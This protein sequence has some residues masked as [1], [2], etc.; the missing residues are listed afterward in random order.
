MGSVTA[1]MQVW[2][3]ADGRRDVQHLLGGAGSSPWSSSGRLL[4]ALRLP[5]QSE[6]ISVG[7]KL[8]V[9]VFRAEAGK[10]KN[11]TCG[12]CSELIDESRAKQPGRI[13]SGGFSEVCCL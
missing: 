12:E 7:D 5:P 13:S 2:R 8:E 9:G 11:S 10:Q 4:L 3:L 6:A 1:A